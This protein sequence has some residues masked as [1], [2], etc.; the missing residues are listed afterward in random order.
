MK[1]LMIGDISG[2]SGRD[3]ISKYLKELVIKN[4]IDFVIANGEN[5]SHGISIIKKHYD[6]LKKLG[7][8]VITSGNHIF[9]KPEVAK[10][11]SSTPDLLKPLNMNSF[12]PGNGTIK[13]IK[14]GKKIR[15]T[16]IMGH[17]F[18]EHVNNEYESFDKLLASD[19]DIDIHIVD[20]HA[21]ATAEKKAFAW[22]YDGRIS[23]LV[24]T[25]THVQTA[26]NRILPKGTAFISDLGMTGSY[27]SILG[28]QPKEV[29]QKEK[30]GIRC[31][32]G[33]KPSLLPGQFC[34]A[35]LEID[36]HTNKAVSLNRV[37]ITPSSK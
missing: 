19:N 12:T 11:I 22:N 28:V 16:N 8:D 3:C 9:G 37:F 31:S 25:H 7:V 4:N 18:M 36:D 26:D 10:Y 5:I 23:C 32:G 1:F 21:E 24:G 33:F 34:G 20:M 35:I 30:V 2:K 27:D 6:F 29:I 15:V 17:V 14:K 13:V